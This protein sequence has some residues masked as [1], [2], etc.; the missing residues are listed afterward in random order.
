ME[1]DRPLLHFNAQDRGCRRRLRDLSLSLV[2]KLSK[3]ATHPTHTHTTPTI[4][5]F[6][7]DFAI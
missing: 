4:Q 1:E 5:A 3:Q 2:Q 7:D 6:L